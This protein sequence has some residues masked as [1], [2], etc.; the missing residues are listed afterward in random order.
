MN[1]VL[2]G[3]L[4]LLLGLL[5]GYFLRGNTR[6]I[7]T[8]TVPVTQ[9]SAQSSDNI[10]TKRFGTIGGKATN[11]LGDQITLAN[12]QNQTG[13]FTLAKNLR[14]YLPS[15]STG[16]SSASADLKSIKLNQAAIFT[17]EWINNGYQLTII[18]YK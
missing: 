8:P 14:I 9:S 18:S 13:I 10:F 17:L 1:K 3:I 15:N 2:I 6:E 12:N 11:L 7:K 4:S 5:L 16:S